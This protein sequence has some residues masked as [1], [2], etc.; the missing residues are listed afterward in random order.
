MISLKQV[1]CK[2]MPRVASERVVSRR[3]L[4]WRGLVISL[5]VVALALSLATR[6]IHISFDLNPTAHSD[7]ARTKV[8]HRD[9][10]NCEWTSPVADVSV[11][12]V[13]EFSIDSEP[14]EEVHFRLHYDSLYNRPPPVA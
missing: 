13:T 1:H 2:T 11:L 10:D 7:S 14:A 8:Q 4:S 3:L 6:V 5:S 9:A 12:W